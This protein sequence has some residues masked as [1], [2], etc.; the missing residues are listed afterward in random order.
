M[1]V[2]E[3]TCKKITFTN[4]TLAFLKYKLNFSSRSGALHIT[5]T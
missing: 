3:Q 5:V 1:Y 2:R 4:L